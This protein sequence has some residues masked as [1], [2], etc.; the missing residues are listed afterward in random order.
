MTL[1]QIAF[2][3]FALIASGGLLLTGM[4]F[5]GVRIPGFMGMAHGLGGLVSLATLFAANLRGGDLT[6]S[7]AWWALGVFLAG[8][9][10]GLVLFRV[11]FNKAPLP[12]A[13]MHGSI[14]G[15]GLYLLYH[16]AF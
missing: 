16:A 11:L 8:T 15:V 3:M 13:A 1:T 7:L 12:L 6:P 9:I 14:G 2:Y 10:G 4:I 5:I